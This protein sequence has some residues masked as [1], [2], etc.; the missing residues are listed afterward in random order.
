M[1]KDPESLAILLTAVIA[2]GTFLWRIEK[3][4]AERLAEILDLKLENINQ[5]VRGI[6]EN[7]KECVTKAECERRIEYED[8][9]L[10][11]LQGQVKTVEET[12]LSFVQHLTE[13]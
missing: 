8:K 13:G 10:Q 12:N 2:L 1:F 7:I 5:V 9:F 4:R 6:A 11:L 3:Y